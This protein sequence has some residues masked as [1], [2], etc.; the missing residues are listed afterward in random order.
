M[1][2]RLFSGLKFIKNDLRSSL[3]DSKIK[4]II[5]S[6]LARMHFLGLFFEIGVWSPEFE[7]KSEVP[8][9]VRSPI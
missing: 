3:K 8:S 6:I 5:F 2:K 7:V 9:G 4:D 1:A